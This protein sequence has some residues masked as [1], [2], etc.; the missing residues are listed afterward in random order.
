[1]PVCMLMCIPAHLPAPQVG[2]A[3]T[4]VLSRKRNRNS[5]GL[6]LGVRPQGARAGRS[7]ALGA[8]APHRL[9]DV[10]HGISHV[11][12]EASEGHEEVPMLVA[13]VTAEVDQEGTDRSGGLR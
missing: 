4:T 8:G 1:M 9:V 10:I 2:G 13:S 5:E 3:Q 7:G 11:L 12:R 6:G